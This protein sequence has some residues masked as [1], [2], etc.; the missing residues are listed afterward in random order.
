MSAI[1]DVSDSYLHATLTWREQPVAAGVLSERILACSR[2]SRHYDGLDRGCAE[3]FWSVIA[4]RLSEP[5]AQKSLETLP[6]AKAR[7]GVV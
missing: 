1:A 2:E 6:T 7:S 3:A 5:I 4:Y